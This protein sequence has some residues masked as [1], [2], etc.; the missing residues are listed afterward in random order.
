[1]SLSHIDFFF[2]ILTE[3]YYHF[4]S[5]KNIINLTAL[6]NY[7]RKRKNNRNLIQIKLI[8]TELST[9]YF[10]ISYIFSLF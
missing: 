7:L 4:A 8:N 9:T 5:G 10:M 6:V 2:Q 3:V 1:M